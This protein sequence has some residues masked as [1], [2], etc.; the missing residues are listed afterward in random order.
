MGEEDFGHHY[1]RS[2]KM[3]DETDVI[4]CVI[5]YVITFKVK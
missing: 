2:F 1:Q 4:I 3:M 5:Y